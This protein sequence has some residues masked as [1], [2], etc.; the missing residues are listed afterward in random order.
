[1]LLTLG[2][3]GAPIA[4]ADTTS[5]VTGLINFEGLAT[6]VTDMTRG[7]DSWPGATVE[8]VPICGGSVGG[9]DLPPRALRGARFELS[10]FSHA[11]MRWGVHG[12]VN[13]GIL[14]NQGPH[15]HREPC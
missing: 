13:V 5:G 4:R 14:K 2:V 10:A 1:M 8:D 6:S 7:G 15:S 12:V 9:V 11:P 3:L